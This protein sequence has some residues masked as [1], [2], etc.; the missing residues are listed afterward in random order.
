[1]QKTMT[2]PETDIEVEVEYCLEPYEPQTREDP[3]TEGGAYVEDIQLNNES[4]IEALKPEIIEKLEEELTIDY[5]ENAYEA[6]VAAA[7]AKYDEMKG[8]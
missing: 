1:M 6:K 2:L 7:E 4:I 8:N 3:G 5:G